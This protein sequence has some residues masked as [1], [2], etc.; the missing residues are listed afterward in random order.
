MHR[1]SR[2]DASRQTEVYKRGSLG[3]AQ[4]HK[5]PEFRTVIFV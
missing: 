1:V 2:Y 4:D 5:P 3:D